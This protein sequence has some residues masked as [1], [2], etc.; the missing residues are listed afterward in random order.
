[1]KKR[2]IV[3]GAIS[4]AVAVIVIGLC[5]LFFGN[6]AIRL[7]PTSLSVEQIDGK[8]N[9]VSEFNADYGYKFKLE[10]FQETENDFKVITTVLSNSNVL[11]ISDE[12]NFHIVAGKK[13]RFAVCFTNENGATEGKYC[14]Y[15]NWIPSWSL[16]G[17]DYDRVKCEDDV[18]T[19]DEVNSADSYTLSVV[20]N[21]GK[22]VLNAK[23]SEE[24]FLL[25]QI[26]SVG[27]FKVYIVANSTNQ[28]LMSSDAGVGASVSI[29]RNNEIVSVKVVESD[30]QIVCTQLVSK[31][32]IY[33]DGVFAADLD[34]Q[35]NWIRNNEQVEYKFSNLSFLGIDFENKEVKIKSLVNLSLHVKE[36]E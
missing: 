21:A 26:K 15:V 13:Y 22:V 1:M 18:L 20:D 35:Q 10:Q 2:G 5:F 3:I 9:L 36:S 17:V 27:D 14:D 8:Y 28:N 25:S 19:W 11:N 29:V 7:I 24:K 23:V 16:D 32:V 12:P 34:V 30:L 4:L 6:K 33:V 31:F